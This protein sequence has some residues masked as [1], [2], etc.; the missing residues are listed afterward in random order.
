[1][2]RS[3]STHDKIATATEGLNPEFRTHLSKMSTPNM[4]AL[5][6]YLV[7]MKSETNPSDNYRKNI[8]K[9]VSLLS[10]FH[11][12]NL[13]FKAMKRD[14][15]L[16]FLDHLRKPDNKDP[17]HKWIGTYN[18]YITVLI[19][20]FKW[21]YNPDMSSKNR[22]KPPV[23]QNIPAL[24]RKEISN[25]SP[26][27]LWTEE[28]DRI[29]LKY[30]PTKRMKFYHTVSRDASDRPHEVLKLKVGDIKWKLTPDKKQ[31]AEISLSGK[32]GKRHIPLFHSIPYVKDYLDHEH[33]SPNTDAPLF[34]GLGKRLGKH[35]GGD[36]LRR[37]YTQLKRKHFPELLDTDIPEEDKDIIRQLLRK[38]WNPYIRRHTGLT[39]KSKKIPAL[40]TQYAGWTPNSK[41][42]QKYFH[43]FANESSNSLLEAYDYTPNDRQKSDI[44]KPKY[45]PQCNEGNKPD[46]K[47]CAKCRMVL[48]YDGYAETIEAEKQKDGRIQDLEKQLK[49][50]EE[51]QRQSFEE[52]KVENHRIIKEAMAKFKA[53]LSPKALER[54][55]RK[56]I[57]EVLEE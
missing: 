1:M 34:C 36:Q 24:K 6:D 23:V 26:E 27:D 43:Y 28:D 49:S 51:S 53:T 12:N 41:M 46:S 8:I 3:E 57:I 15:V 10:R 17:K 20:F 54:F 40:M 52:F 44:L 50:M 39:E 4:L 25:Y 29:F 33:P 13:S 16:L 2:Q 32:T 22:A 48:S 5:A 47:F 11:K 55:S 37:I 35:I 7:S 45:C 9:V 21:L 31:Y 56:R 19:K 38:P 42:P 30:C 14:N 18:L